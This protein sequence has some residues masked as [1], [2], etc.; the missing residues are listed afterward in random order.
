MIV[1]DR[2]YHGHTAA[3]LSLSPYKYEHEGGEDYAEEWVHKVQ[4]PD[5]YRSGHRDQATAADLYAA[6]WRRRAENARGARAEVGSLLSSSNRVCPSP[7]IL[8]PRV[9][10]KVLRPGSRSRWVV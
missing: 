7:M 2:A 4:C 1:V 5:V 8:P 10:E 9:P 3:T 6:M